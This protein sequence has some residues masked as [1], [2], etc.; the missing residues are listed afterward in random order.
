MKTDIP[1]PVARNGSSSSPAGGKGQASAR[2]F[3]VQELR[4][5]S[6]QIAAG[7]FRADE[8]TQL[9]LMEVHPWR[10]HAY[11]NISEQDWQPS[12][13]QGGQEALVLR[14]RDPRGRVADQDVEVDGRRN[15]WYVDLLQGGGAYTAE[16]GLLQG[17]GD[18]QVLAQSNTVQLPM[19][20]PSP[21]RDY[22]MGL[23]KDAEPPQGDAPMFDKSLEPPPELPQQQL[24]PGPGQVSEPF[25]SAESVSVPLPRHEPKLDVSGENGDEEVYGTDFPAIEEYELEQEHERTDQFSSAMVKS[26]IPQLPAMDETLICPTDL[27]LGSHAT[28]PAGPSAP[29]V[30]PITPA[31]S[32]Q[33]EQIESRLLQEHPLN[34]VP[35]IAQA[36]ADVIHEQ[37]STHAPAVRR[38]VMALEDALGAS[39]FSGSL[40]GAGLQVDSRLQLSG[41]L[42]PDHALSLFGE[43]VEVDAEG[44]FTVSLPLDKGPELLALL[45]RLRQ[46]KREPG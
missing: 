10:L 4:T 11:W 39:L 7:W 32:Q 31:A 34:P 43:A 46:H 44:R 36:G 23:V 27:S 5:I 41:Q 6:F 20:E 29:A 21:Q 15:N 9:T 45:Y 12:R 8:A 19:A 40:G 28:L 35:V 24:Y 42:D 30:E 16:L 17:N 13:A 25:P 1:S 33:L 18:L 3:S 14:L 22:T 2:P 37:V 26:E 38:P